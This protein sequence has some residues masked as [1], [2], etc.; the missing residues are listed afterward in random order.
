MGSSVI[1]Q[2]RHPLAWRV[3][4]LLRAA[5]FAVGASS[6]SLEVISGVG[7]ARSL[8]LE[9]VK[10]QPRTMPQLLACMSRSSKLTCNLAPVR[11][12]MMEYVFTLWSAAAPP[13]AP[14]AAP[15]LAASGR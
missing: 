7:D 5:R 4:H 6:L 2:L 12:W 11:T 1:D 3:W 14:A 9:L 8:A 13:P 10:H 15:P